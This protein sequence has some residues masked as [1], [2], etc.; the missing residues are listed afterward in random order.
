M[1]H[2][3]ILYIFTFMALTISIVLLFVTPESKVEETSLIFMISF[4][5]TAI[6]ISA[7]LTLLTAS[8]FGKYID[9]FFIAL[10]SVILSCWIYIRLFFFALGDIG[11]GESGLIFHSY[12]GVGVGIV[13]GII[14]IIINTIILVRHKV[15]EKP[16]NNSAQ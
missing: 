16:Y 4:F 8:L 5:I 2:K 7:S 14:S 12:F 9:K 6:C 11:G 10:F 3:K 13:V 1:K 15:E